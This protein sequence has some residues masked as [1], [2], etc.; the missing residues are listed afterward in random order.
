V[1]SRNHPPAPSLACHR[2]FKDKKLVAWIKERGTK[3]TCDWCEARNVYVVDLLQLG[4]LFEPLVKLYHPSDFHGDFL[5]DL[6]EGDWE[7]FSDRIDNDL[8][9]DLVADIMD[10]G[11]DAKERSCIGIDYRGLFQSRDPFH[12]SLEEIWEVRAESSTKFDPDED[13]GSKCEYEDEG[14]PRLDQIAF[15]VED[16]GA[17]YS[18]YIDRYRL[19]EMGAPPPDRTPAGRA[20]RT[21]EPVLYMASDMQT[22]L[23]EVR[24]WKGAPVSVAKMKLADDFRILDL[25]K[26]YSIE[27]PFFHESLQ[28]ILETNHLMNRF[29]KELSRPVMPHEAEELYRPTQH[30][31]DLV[32]ATGSAGIAYPSAMGPGHNIVLFDPGAATPED[33]SHHRVEKLAFSSRDLGTHEP[34]HEEVPWFR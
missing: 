15:A 5:S 31:C 10:A 2:C 19:D 34:P 30:L 11:V 14:Y 8:A 29:A 26:E 27:S 12:S 22:A 16:R 21:G 13:E 24:A 9:R 1:V 17:T 6:L 33:V 23:A 20:N 28:W 32:K 18:P 4:E 7:I 3:G 25:T